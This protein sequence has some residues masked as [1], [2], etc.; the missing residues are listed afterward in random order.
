VAVV[1]AV[2]AMACC[3]IRGGRAWAADAEDADTED[4]RIRHGLELRR[5]GNERAALDQL[6]R[7][8]A[9][10]RSPRAAAQLGFVEQALGLWPQA[11][12]HVREALAATD[13]PW[14]RKNR[15]TVEGALATI[16]AHIGHVQID[17]GV[18]GAQ[19]TVNGRPVG[20]IPLPDA[21]PVSA[22]PVDIEVRALGYGPAL[23]TVSVAAGEL[24]RVP[25]TLQQIARAPVQ[26]P[27]FQ[28]G[29][30]AAPRTSASSLSAPGAAP[31]LRIERQDPGRGKRM[32]GIGLVAGGIVAVGGGVAA[33]V[34]AKGK[35][36]A[37][38][39]D[40]AASRPYNES[41][42]NW[43]GYE[44][45]AGVLYVVGGAAIVGGVILYVAGRS[46]NEESRPPTVSSVALRPTATPGRAG[47]ALS[48]R[49]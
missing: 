41:N 21:V 38:G 5:Q 1:V 47:A 11:E 4:A 25:F 8:Y 28:P 12:A 10:K 2:S 17:G 45:G 44:T 14:V 29:S 30:P 24:M 31:A 42:G 16:R 15:G 9:V 37:I 34:V 7:A 46:R 39:T 49:F 35:F 3:L 6:E 27:S 43:K 23:K 22:G 33:S 19:V 20:L 32:A 40:A 36:D 13:A 48:V 18:P 26:P